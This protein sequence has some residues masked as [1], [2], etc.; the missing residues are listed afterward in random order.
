M[1]AA[2]IGM[3]EN[4]SGAGFFEKAAFVRGVGESGRGE[5][6]ECDGAV[7]QKIFCLEDDAHCSG[8][9]VLKDFVVR[10]GLSFDHCLHEVRLGCLQGPKPD[11]GG[12]GVKREE[13]LEDRGDRIDGVKGAER[14]VFLLLVRERHGVERAIEVRDMVRVVIGVRDETTEGSRG[15]P[16]SLAD[17]FELFG[18]RRIAFEND[19]IAEDGDRMDIQRPEILGS[20]EGDDRGNGVADATSAG[21]IPRVPMSSSSQSS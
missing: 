9:E 2:N 20:Q 14:D 19:E 16:G 6:L 7:K 17:G 4:R 12:R 18:K 5:A 13:L 10:D 15:K 1:D 21:E 11:F 3:V 8:A